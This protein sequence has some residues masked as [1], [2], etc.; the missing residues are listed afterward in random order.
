MILAE[1]EKRYFLNP[2]T[3]GFDEYHVHMLMQAAPRYSP[4]RVVQIVKSITA[5]EIFN[6]FPEICVIW[7]VRRIKD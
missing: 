6:K 4:S 2:E 1:I 5:R 7:T 3:I